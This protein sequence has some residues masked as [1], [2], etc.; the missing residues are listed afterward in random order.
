MMHKIVNLREESNLFDNLHD[1]LIIELML[2]SNFLRVELYRSSP[3]HRVPEILYHVS[4]DLETEILD[5]RLAPLNDDWSIVVWI[6][7][8]GLGVYSYQV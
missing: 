3:Y 4:M 6:F 1:I 5:S 2:L 7:S 8:F